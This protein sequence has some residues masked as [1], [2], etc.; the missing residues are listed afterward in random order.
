[1]WTYKGGCVN[2]E[3]FTNLIA[4][5][6]VPILKPFDDKNPIHHVEQV[7]T[8]IQNTSAI[9]QYS[10]TAL[11]TIYLFCK[12]IGIFKATKLFM[13][14]THIHYAPQLMDFNS[15]NYC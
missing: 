7:A 3:F 5:T 15:G 12:T 9:L 10:H 13:K 1:M 8:L 2:G 11:I 14:H 4:R 6:L